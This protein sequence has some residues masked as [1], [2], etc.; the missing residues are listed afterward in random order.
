YSCYDLKQP[1]KVNLSVYFLPAVGWEKVIKIRRFSNGTAIT[2]LLYFLRHLS[3]AFSSNFMV[4]SLHPILHALQVCRALLLYIQ[5][6]VF[7][8][9]FQLRMSL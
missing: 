3:V 8:D 9:N 1:S 5:N 6:G 2:N 7:L 4:P